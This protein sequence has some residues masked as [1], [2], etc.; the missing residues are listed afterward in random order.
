MRLLLQATEHALYVSESCIFVS[1]S[2]SVRLSAGIF[3]NRSPALTTKFD[4][5]LLAKKSHLVVRAGDP[6]ENEDQLIFLAIKSL[7]KSRTAFGF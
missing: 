7:R 2:Y 6:L 1:E 5:F 4:S 3:F